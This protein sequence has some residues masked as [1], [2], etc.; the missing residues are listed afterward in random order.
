MSSSEQL[1]DGFTGL[2][3]TAKTEIA[4]GIFRFDLAHPQG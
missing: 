4:Q 1:D 2:K 3:V